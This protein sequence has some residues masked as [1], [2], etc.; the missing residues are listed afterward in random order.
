IGNFNRAVAHGGFPLEQSPDRIPWT[1]V[2]PLYTSLSEEMTSEPS[3]GGLATGRQARWMPFAACPVSGHRIA[4]PSGHLA[5]PLPRR[6]FHA[7]PLLFDRTA[8]PQS[9][10]VRR[11]VSQR[12]QNRIGML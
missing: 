2:R 3:M 4:P 10:D 1:I 5:G 6:T 12:L 11:I 8:L 7:A 9:R